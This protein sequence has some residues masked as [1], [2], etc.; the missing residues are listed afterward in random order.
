MYQTRA[1]K[2]RNPSEIAFLKQDKIP[3]KC[4]IVKTYNI[5]IPT[6]K[7]NGSKERMKETREPCC[8]K[9][10]NVV[11]QWLGTKQPFWCGTELEPQRETFL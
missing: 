11:Y 10:G 9:R 4:L 5:I 2:A 7:K 6:K 1:Y 3:R 8:S